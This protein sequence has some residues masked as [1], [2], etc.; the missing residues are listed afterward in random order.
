MLLNNCLQSR[1]V[2]GLSILEFF[3]LKYEESWSSKKLRKKDVEQVCTPSTL[4]D[5]FTV[6]GYAKMSSRNH[7]HHP[8]KF[9]ALPIKTSELENL[10][11][12][13]AYCALVIISP[14][15]HCLRV[16]SSFI[17]CFHQIMSLWDPKTRV[18]RNRNALRF[19]NTVS[20]FDFKN[21][22]FDLG[23][24][25]CQLHKKLFKG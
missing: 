8:R 3:I 1:S 7:C 19:W 21:D 18:K 4:E 12:A 2:N 20:E 9:K 15:W 22:E 24:F 11:Q 13:R 10:V 25:E 16:L 17:L 23:N 6:N 14:F 5:P